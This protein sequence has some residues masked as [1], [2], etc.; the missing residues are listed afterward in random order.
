[1]RDSNTLVS[2]G[3]PVRNG[4]DRI[5]QVVTSVLN[6]DHENLELVICDNASTDN[7]EEVCRSLAAKDNRVVYHRHPV[8]VGLYKNYVSTMKLATGPYFRW[9]G[10]DDWLHPKYMSR[11]LEK[12]AA[13]DRLILVTTQ[14]DYTTE[15]GVTRTA[16]YLGTALGSDDP[17]ARFTEMLQL[18][19]DSYLVIDPLYAMFRREPVL[20]IKR[21]N[22]LR[23]DEVFSTKLALAGPWGHVP[24]VLAGRN[25]HHEPPLFHARKMD[26][27]LWQAYFG[28]AQQYWETLNW[29]KECDLDREQRRRARLAVARTYMQRQ[30]VVMGRR[31]RKLRTIAGDLAGRLW[32]RSP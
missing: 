8:N 14:I 16:P 20:S 22:M 2:V 6:Q 10:D 9:I 32:T 28:T 29:L 21:R 1:M 31:G 12:F 26:V 17:V 23:E 25:W 4:A 5:D 15:D 11:S 13:D 30:Q 18:L 27:P 3:L 24:E 7:T 19:N